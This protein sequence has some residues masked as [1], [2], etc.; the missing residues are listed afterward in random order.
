MH[1]LTC[2]M[3]APFSVCV[4]PHCNG[5]DVMGVVPDRQTA[6]RLE[7]AGPFAWSLAPPPPFPFVI[8]GESTFDWLITAVGSDSAVKLELTGGPLAIFGTRRR[9]SIGRVP[10]TPGNRAYYLPRE[11]SILLRDVLLAKRSQ[12]GQKPT[13]YSRGGYLSRR[14]RAVLM[15]TSI[16]AQ[17]KVYLQS[18]VYAPC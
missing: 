18:T 11:P 15:K 4:C 8:Q 2:A 3:L 12:V 17:G 10:P 6:Q 13:M 7:R 16:H 5:M 9:A 1:I 14:H